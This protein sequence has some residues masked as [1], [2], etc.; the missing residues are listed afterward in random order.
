MWTEKPIIWSDYAEKYYSDKLRVGM[1]AQ[2]VADSDDNIICIDNVSGN[3]QYA[4]LLYTDYSVGIDPIL[5][6]K[7]FN[8]SG[9][10]EILETDKEIMLDGVK[11]TAAN[12]FYQMHCE[13]K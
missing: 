6:L 4:V 7:L 3:Y 11:K 10:I 1:T 13:G 5:Q 8:E 2:F 12:V 9:S